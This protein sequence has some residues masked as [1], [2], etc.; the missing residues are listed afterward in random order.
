MQWINLIL[1]IS[2]ASFGRFDVLAI[3]HD[4][5]LH[6]FEYESDMQPD[7]YYP[8]DEMKNIERK[9]LIEMAEDEPLHFNEK[10]LRIR[11]ALSGATQDAR[12]QRTISEL[13]P[14]RMTM[15]QRV[16]LVALISALTSA[17]SGD[18]ELTL[19]QVRSFSRFLTRNFYILF[20]PFSVDFEK[21][22]IK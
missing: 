12:R 2:C 17:R 7:L 6:D 11:D 15:R 3:N 18:E 19:Q 14:R 10:E 9:M 21:K 22:N 20:L 4:G 1:F 16:A 8:D 13:I 5:D